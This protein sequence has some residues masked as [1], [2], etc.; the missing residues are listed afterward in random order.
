MAARSGQP[1]RETRGGSNAARV[2]EMAP[3]K[4]IMVKLSPNVTDIREIAEKRG[5]LPA[6]DSISCINTLWEWP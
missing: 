1:G 5:K 6:R 4:H 3:D 2:R